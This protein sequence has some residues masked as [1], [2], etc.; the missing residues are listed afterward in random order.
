MRWQSEGERAPRRAAPDAASADRACERCGAPL[1]TLHAGLRDRHFDTEAPASGFAI[2]ACATCDRWVLLPRPSPDA[3][4]DLYRDYYTHGHGGAAPSGFERWVARATAARSLGYAR[5]ASAFERATAP[6]AIGPLRAIGE[7]RAMWLPARLRDAGGGRVLDVGCGDGELLAHL[8]ELGWSVAG[9]E[10]DARARAVAAQRLGGAPVY[11]SAEEAVAAG[12]RA[13]A[14]TLSHVVE[15]AADPEALLA[16]CRR[17]LAPE[18]RLVART[19]NPASAACARFGASW[20][21]W[22]PPRHLRLFG[23]RGLRALVE[24]AGLRVLRSFTSAGSAH[25]AYAASAR[26]ERDGRLPG[27]D[28]GAVP[29][30]V[31][32]ASIAFWL[33]EHARVRRGEGVGEEVVVIAT[34]AGGKEARA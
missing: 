23:E 29:V 31:R 11:A 3:L 13:D 28:L 9:V 18:G 20:L 5:S 24:D 14:V 22:D 15:H 33:R 12:E 8:R 34:L 16:A 25:F 19:P 30:G 27:L 4:D 17:A 2:A 32:L 10:P 1:E 7:A 6:L 21:H 26:L